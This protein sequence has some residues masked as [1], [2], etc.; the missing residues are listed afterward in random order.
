MT[1]SQSIA[2]SISDRVQQDRSA[3]P[4]FSGTGLRLHD[5]FA[6]DNFEVA[7]VRELIRQ[8][9]SLS[10]SLLRAAN[11]SFYSSLDKIASID[12]AVVRL[13]AKSV[14]RL[15][16]MVSQK[17][18][19]QLA[20]P[21]LVPVVDSL[22]RHAVVCAGG[23]EW[24]AHRVGRGELAPTAFMAGMLHDIGQLLV[25]RVIDDLI[26][27]DK[28]FDPPDAVVLEMMRK[29]HAAHGA[30]MLSLWNLPEEYVQIVRE[31]HQEDIGQEDVL[32]AIVRLADLGCNKLGI[33]IV[34]AADTNLAA[35]M[36]AAALRLTEI[37]AAEL[38]IA[39]EDALELAGS[40]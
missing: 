10:A 3:L 33:G 32:L 2:D 35:T 28:K 23:S 38:E 27:S 37:D 40:V 7:E 18:Q 9:Q 6:S 22:W 24:L 20:T 8:D 21:R 11:S 15:V 25:L 16:T 36:E 29:L 14:S 19:Y 4:L 31:H 17:E 12:Q 1:V 39:L 26:S 13:G 34:P 30:E 5:M